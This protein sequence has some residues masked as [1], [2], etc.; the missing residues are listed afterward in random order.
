MAGNMERSLAILELLAKNGGRMPLHAIADQLDIPRSATHR[1]LSMLMAQGYVRQDEV[2]SEYLLSLKLVSL[3]LIYLS[4]SGV[5]DIAQP[6]LDRLA[7]LSGELAR[8]GIIE[9][10][11]VTFVGK[12]QGARSGLRYDP[13]MGSQPPLFCT[14]SGQAW[15]AC[16]SDEEALEIVSRQGFGKPGEWGPKAPHTIQEFLTVLHAARE[17][18]Y[19]VAIETYEA[20]MSSMAA[21]IH[22]PVTKAVVGVVTLAGPVS[23]FSEERINELAPALLEAAADLGTAALSS[24]YFKIKPAAAPAEMS[25]PKRGRKA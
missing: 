13:D 20:G 11:L 22:H 17:R 21:A 15:L 18:G 24:S 14:A 4:T 23:R 7:D 3:A 25:A 6:I 19:G 10:N 8:I 1:L 16:L 5:M 2:H 12:A 9:N